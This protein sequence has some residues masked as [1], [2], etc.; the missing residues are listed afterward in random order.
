[1]NMKANL[2]V[3]GGSCLLARLLSFFGILRPGL[4]V[5]R[6]EDGEGCVV[7]HNLSF[8]MFD[9]LNSASYSILL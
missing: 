8:G 6:S 9:N 1:M 2:R 5:E 3:E 7:T 4:K